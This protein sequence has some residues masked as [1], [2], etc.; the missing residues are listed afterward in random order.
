MRVIVAGWLE[1]AGQDCAAIIRSGASHIMASRRER[2]CVAYDWAVDP[3]QAAT[4]RVYEE[5]ESETDL[6]RHFRDPSYA[7]MRDH[8]QAHGLTGFDVKLY[9]VA[10]TAAVYDEAGALPAEMFG[11]PIGAA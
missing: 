8:L 9:S 7:A 1:F 11:V 3:L 4:I 6:G 10:A 2:G 5:W